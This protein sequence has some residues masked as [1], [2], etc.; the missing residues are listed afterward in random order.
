MTEASGTA[1][2]EA[3]IADIPVM[4]VHIHAQ[5]TVTPETAWELGVRNGMITV[6]K[7]DSGKF[8]YRTGPNEI[9]YPIYDTDGTV[10]ELITD[11]TS[12]FRT[13]DGIGVQLDDAGKPTNIEYDIAPGRFKS[14]DQVMA[15]V[16]GHRHP[17]GGI[18]TADDYAFVVEE[19]LKSASEQ[20]VM[21]SE[22]QQNIRIAY[23]LFLDKPM[24]E[25]TDQ[26]KLE[27][28]KQFY[29]LASELVDR[30][31]DYGVELRFL[32]CFN[33][34]GAAGLNED[35]DHRALQAADWLIES[36]KYAPGVFV[37]MQSAGHEGDPTGWPKHLKKGYEKA[38]DAGF[39]LAT[40]G[41]EGIGVAHLMDV[42]T[43]LQPAHNAHG[44]QIIESKQAIEEY[45]AMENLPILV[46]M[47]QINI[48][49]G[50]PVH[51]DS[52]GNPVQTDDKTKMVAITSLGDHP[53]FTLLREHELPLA[54]AT[55]NPGMGGV[56]YK[57]MLLELAGLS[58]DPKVDLGDHAPMTAEELVKCC[59]C[60]AKTA[61]CSPET[62][63]EYL[64]DLA[65]WA[66]RY[67]VKLDEPI[68]DTK[69]S[70]QAKQAGSS[71][72]FMK[73]TQ[74]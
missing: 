29:Q 24:E 2:T 30:A 9:E 74:N 38:K 22:L 48:A 49:L 57:Q 65:E 21:Y 56:P 23:P 28:R 63:A 51:R 47:P 27:A 35:S 73:G 4:D 36:K 8:H 45:K 17:P 19:Y 1:L 16:Q 11:Y 53:F 13:K 70:D 69:Y 54:L 60:A 3:M 14:F 25:A 26:E 32:N 15:I 64:K 33:K 6:E 37:G 52:E 72:G 7:D 18:Q 20:N 40:H 58:K 34:T 46:M 10:M 55:D 43:T 67:N 66:E 71:K 50:S 68:V 31:K 62:K 59:L 12:I 44:F 42:L 61:F 39:G 41:G 5:G